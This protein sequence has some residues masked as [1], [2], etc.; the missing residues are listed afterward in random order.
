M[1]LLDPSN[2]DQDPEKKPRFRQ[3]LIAFLVI[4][5]AGIGYIIYEALF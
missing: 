4:L 5:L 2:S 3:D 1:S